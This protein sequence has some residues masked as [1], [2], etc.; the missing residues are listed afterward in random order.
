MAY[1][2]RYCIG[3]LLCCFTITACSLFQNNSQVNKQAMCK[4]LNYRIINNGATGNQV[5]ATQ[6]RAERDTLSRTYHEEGC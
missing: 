5:L 3:A 2:I 1:V 4:E 6:Q